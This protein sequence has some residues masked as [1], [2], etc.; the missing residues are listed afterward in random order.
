MSFWLIEAAYLV[1][2]DR[3]FE[4]ELDELQAFEKQGMLALED[5]WI[6]VTPRGRFMV[7]SICMVFDRY[8]REKRPGGRY[9]RVI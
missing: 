8:L 9:S 5:G 6:S 2:F 3:H 7:R 4:A 1:A